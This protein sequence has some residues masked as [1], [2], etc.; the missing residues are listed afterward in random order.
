MSSNEENPPLSNLFAPATTSQTSMAPAYSDQNITRRSLYIPS[1]PSEILSSLSDEFD[2]NSVLEAP[3]PP[4]AGDSTLGHIT[5]PE[6]AQHHHQK[7]HQNHQ[8]TPISQ[9]PPPLPLSQQQS[10]EPDST[11]SIFG[12]INNAQRSLQQKDR[13][14]NLVWRLAKSR[15]QAATNASKVSASATILKPD[16]FD[17]ALF[18]NHQNPTPTDTSPES[19]AGHSPFIEDRDLLLNGMLH[20]SIAPASRKRVAAFSPMISATTGASQQQD[21]HTPSQL[22]NEYGMLSPDDNDVAEYQLD[23]QLDDLAGLNE[24]TVN[25]FMLPKDNMTNDSIFNNA[26]T[27]ASLNTHNNNIIANN[28]GNNNNALNNN[29]TNNISNIS[30]SLVNTHS[31][32]DNSFRNSSNHNFNNANSINFSDNNNFGNINNNN[33]NGD[34]NNDVT[35]QN[36]FEFSLDPLAFEGLADMMDQPMT[37]RTPT[38]NDFDFNVDLSEID[39]ASSSLGMNFHEIIPTNDRFVATRSDNPGQIA[40]DVTAAQSPGIGSPAVETGSSFAPS[41]SH[42]QP[43]FSSRLRANE[44]T[45]PKSRSNLPVNLNGFSHV[46]GP[47]EVHGFHTGTFS[48]GNSSNSIARPPNPGSLNLH[49]YTGKTAKFELGL[50]DDDESNASN[51]TTPALSPASSYIPSSPYTESGHGRR[52]V[53]KSPSASNFSQQP[54]PTETE[55]LVPRKTKLARTESQSSVSSSMKNAYNSTN[56]SSANNTSTSG[57]INNKSSNGKESRNSSTVTNISTQPKIEVKNPG[58]LFSVSSLPG[59]TSFPLNSQR[60]KAR[61][62]SISSSAKNFSTLAAKTP[63]FST[64]LNLNFDT[65]VECTNCHTR[66]TPLWRRN[67]E[68]LPL[69]NACGLFLKLHGE[70]RPLSLKT[71]VIKKRNRGSNASRNNINSTSSTDISKNVDSATKGKTAATKSSSNLLALATSSGNGATVIPIAKNS[72][73]PNSANNSVSGAASGS[74]GEP[75]GS[76]NVGKHVP[77]AP[78]RMIALAPAPPKPVP[79]AIKPSPANASAPLTAAN[80]FTQSPFQECKGGVTKP[81]RKKKSVY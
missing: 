72:S 63:S 58:Q 7:N 44:I 26:T 36:A 46:A 29:F 57:N 2:L 73:N 67:P 8:S 60:N 42:H 34:M 6:I 53:I 35:N 75:P 32:F 1:D 27:P 30:S 20:S 24:T 51:L 61:P 10:F 54:P 14:D 23:S 9:Q 16:P 47:R 5:K 19:N 70:V 39:N 17:S 41:Y 71:D 45:S 40:F 22:S 68:G 56:H 33:T 37:S 80:S 38:D 4:S 48:R 62:F 52:Q 66:T 55:I 13:I 59:V 11:E 43:S 69:C 64:S 21:L 65:P 31:S 74:V 81:E 28:S 78:K 50:D 25:D 15:N 12:I 49:F 79:V 76:T 18:G 3:N 77:I